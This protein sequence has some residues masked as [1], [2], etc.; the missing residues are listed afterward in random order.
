MYV[1]VAALVTESMVS[2][3]W[4]DGEY[5]HLDSSPALFRHA[6]AERDGLPEAA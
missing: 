1:Q 6:I 4:H 5:G 3:Q 2:S